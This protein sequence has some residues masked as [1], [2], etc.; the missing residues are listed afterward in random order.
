MPSFTW[1]SPSN[2]A[3]IKYWGKYGQQLPRNASISFTLN[4]AYTETTLSYT[5]KADKNDLSFEFWF[6]G[7]AKP[8]FHPKIE[9]FLNTIKAEF[10][11][12][13]HYHWK[14]ESH[15]SFPH[16]VG[17]ASSASGMSAL[18]L[19][20]CSATKELGLLDDSEDFLKKASHWAR[21][22]SG[23]A[24]RSVYPYLGVWGESKHIEGSSNTYAIPYY[25]D[26]DP[27]FRTYKDAILIV[28]KREKSVSS[29]A[30]HQLMEG[31]PFAPLR[32]QLADENMAKLL[33]AMK[34]G[35]LETFGAIVEEEALMLHAL[36]MTSRPSYLLLEANTIELIHKLRA[37]REETKLPLYFSLDAGPNLHLLYPKHIE[38]AAEKFIQEELK[39]LCDNQYWLQDEVG[40]GATEM[41]LK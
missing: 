34:V 26:L 32:Y 14:I 40:L 27:V 41:Q 39:P 36:M 17:I 37:W 35:D 28:S 25:E 19:C 1:R 21:L 22:G 7:A 2:I 31:N 15:N 5:A 20:F 24:C 18:A 23:S 3:L 33:T 13:T 30:G 11:Q 6:D 10:P 38:E 12:I 29:T 8:S 4:N 16:S 9:K